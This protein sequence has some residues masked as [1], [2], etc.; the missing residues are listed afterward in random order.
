LREHCGDD[1]EFVK[2]GIAVSGVVALIQGPHPG[3][4]VAIR[5]TIS[6]RLSSPTVL[7]CLGCGLFPRFSFRWRPRCCHCSCLVTC[8]VLQRFEA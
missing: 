2:E 3:P 5:V 1:L 8:L 7:S 4:C 6:P